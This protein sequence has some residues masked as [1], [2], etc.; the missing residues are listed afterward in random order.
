MFF[1]WHFSAVDLTPF[2]SLVFPANILVEKW[3]LLRRNSKRYDYLSLSAWWDRMLNEEFNRW[4]VRYEGSCVTATYSCFSNLFPCST[5]L[6]ITRVIKK[7]LFSSAMLWCREA[8]GDVMVMGGIC[9]SGI[10]IGAWRNLIYGQVIIVAL[11][12]WWGEK[13]EKGWIW[14]NWAGAVC[15]YQQFWLVH[16]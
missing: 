10:S 11:M 7:N 1:H 9:F 15:W 4:K 6:N 12:A 8:A 5:G 2:T 14:P 16:E 13:E 3:V